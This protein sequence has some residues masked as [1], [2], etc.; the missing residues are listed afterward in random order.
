VADLDSGA[1]LTTRLDQPITP[2][3]RAERLSELGHSFDPPIFGGQ[4]QRLT[5]RHHYLPSPQ[6]WLAAD[7][8]SSY[9]P[10]G[11][12]DGVVWWDL[13]QD[14]DDSVY[15]YGMYFFFAV[16]PVGLSLASI[17]LG[18]NAFEGVQSR[19]M[20]RA[21]GTQG[22]GS[23]SVP[24]DRAFGVHTVDF[25]FVSPAAPQPL[26]IVMELGKGIEAM[27]FMEISLAEAPPVVDPGPAIDP[28]GSG[29]AG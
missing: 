14:F 3:S 9:S 5:P 12:S 10:V 29:H 11:E 18:G 1:V 8:C 4:S 25:T 28:G 15:V 16:A 13:P 6:T 7:M 20:L 17:T 26:E 19:V 27:A 24:V 22:P 2:P 21:Y 23:L